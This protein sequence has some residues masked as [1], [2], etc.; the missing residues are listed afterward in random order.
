MHEDVETGVKKPKISKGNE[1]KR[2]KHHATR[3][4]T[5][6]LLIDHCTH[7]QV[8]TNHDASRKSEAS[9]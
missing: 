6:Q 2:K 7:T 4:V 3:H 1:S 8:L 9:G 5:E